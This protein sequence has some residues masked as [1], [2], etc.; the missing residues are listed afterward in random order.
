[1]KLCACAPLRG[2]RN[3]PPSDPMPERIPEALQEKLTKRLTFYQDIGIQLFYRDRYPQQP[4]SVTEEII[5][6]K[7]VQKPQPV[8]PVVETRPAPPRLDVFPA[9]SGPS[10]FEAMNRIPDDT[11]LKIQTDLVD[12]TSC[13]L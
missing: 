12:F 10:L 6:P 4:A 7:P 5:L 9:A 2:P 1:M 13:K 3:A 8:R 11:L